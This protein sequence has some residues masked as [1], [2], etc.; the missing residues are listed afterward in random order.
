MHG[1]MASY[2]AIEKCAKLYYFDTPEMRIRTTLIKHACMIE[3]YTK[4]SLE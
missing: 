3:K 4:L 2:N 1:P